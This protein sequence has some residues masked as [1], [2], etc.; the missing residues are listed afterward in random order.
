MLDPLSGL[1]VAGAGWTL[2]ARSAGGG[3]KATDLRTE[4]R[5]RAEAMRDRWVAGRKVKAGRTVKSE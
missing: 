5:G 1:P 2:D 3:Q 4:R